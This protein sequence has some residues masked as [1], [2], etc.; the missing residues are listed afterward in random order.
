MMLTNVFI[1][2]DA[3]HNRVQVLFLGGTTDPLSRKKS[4]LYYEDGA[5]AIDRP[6]AICNGLTHEEVNAVPQIMAFAGRISDKGHTP[7]KTISR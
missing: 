5:A 6:N 3:K 1:D 4:G 2:P 7:P